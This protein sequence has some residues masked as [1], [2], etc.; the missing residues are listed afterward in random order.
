MSAQ[1]YPSTPQFNIDF[2]S[3]LT[4]LE[5]SHSDPIDRCLP[6]RTGDTVTSGNEDD[7][8]FSENATPYFA[9]LLRRVMSGDNCATLGVKPD[10]Y[11]LIAFMPPQL[12]ASAL[13]T[14]ELPESTLYW[15]N[16]N[17]TSPSRLSGWK[18]SNALYAHDH[19][20]F[21]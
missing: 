1:E 15:V 11:L 18:D 21:I 20:R 2:T 6:A 10:Y 16:S 19:A 5:C 14:I 12:L 8:A 4:T 7:T 3:S 17:A 9:S 13:S